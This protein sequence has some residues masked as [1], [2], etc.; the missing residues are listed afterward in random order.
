MLAAL[1]GKKEANDHAF[2]SSM[3]S[4]SGSEARLSIIADGTTF[5]GDFETAGNVRID[6]KIIG[7]IIST[8]SVAIGKGGSVE[9]NITAATIKI[10]GKVQGNIEASGL[11]V[12]SASSIVNGEIKAK[13]LAVE[14]GAVISGKI[15]M[16][17]NST[18][19]LNTF[20][21][22]KEYAP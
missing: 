15:T 20:A 4:S 8:A 14:E 18:S 16:D 7:N 1:F 17:T 12:L 22:N 13:S 2:A 5:R 19:E 11:L 10:S 6:G 9:G 21:T 3:G